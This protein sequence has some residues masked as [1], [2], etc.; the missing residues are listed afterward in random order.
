V[1][2]KGHHRL[3]NVPCVIPAV[4][5]ASLFGSGCRRGAAVIAV[6]DF[7]DALV[8]VASGFEVNSTTARIVAAQPSL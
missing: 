3:G 7:A 2:W 8:T 5:S 1:I 4:M 6:V